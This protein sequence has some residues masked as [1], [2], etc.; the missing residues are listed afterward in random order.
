[1]DYSRKELERNN[2]PSQFQGSCGKQEARFHV[3]I[4]TGVTRMGNVAM[5][6]MS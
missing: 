5:Q 3:C 1:M 2:K 6:E 4:A